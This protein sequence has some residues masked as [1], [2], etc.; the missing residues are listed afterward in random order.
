VRLWGACH[1]DA[2]SVAHRQAHWR[3]PVAHVA[4]VEVLNDSA[5][6]CVD[7]AQDTEGW[8]VATKALDFIA[9]H[10]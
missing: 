3:V 10:Q 5:C 6:L 9:M 7:F 1:K 2:A 8:R 4:V